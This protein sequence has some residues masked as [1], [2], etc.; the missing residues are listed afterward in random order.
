MLL[1]LPLLKILRG[2]S[3]DDDDAAKDSGGGERQG[4]GLALL[5]SPDHG[6]FIENEA[7][8]RHALDIIS[9]SRSVFGN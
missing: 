4:G 9:L 2:R 7:R 5:L 8:R 1:K 6:D 3:D